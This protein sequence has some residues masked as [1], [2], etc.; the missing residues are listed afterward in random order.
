MIRNFAVF[1]GRLQGG[2]LSLGVASL[3][4]AILFGCGGGSGPGDPSPRDRDP[5]GRPLETYQQIGLIA[6][7]GHFPAVASLST[8][9]GPADSTYVLFG[10]SLPNNALRFQR[11][12]NGF[13]G[14]YTVTLAFARDSQV[15]Q[16]LERRE[17][18]RI[19]TFAET[20]RTDESIVF[21]QIVSL[22]P[23]TYVVN[24]QAADAHSSRGFRMTDTLDVPAYGALSHRLA[25]PILV[26]RGRG[27]SDRVAP[28]DIILN[29]RHTIPYGSDAPRVYIESYGADL[30]VPITL[31]V[32]D[33][34]GVTVWSAQAT[35]AEGDALV[36]H[37]TLDLPEGTLPLGKLWVEV[38]S[39]GQANSPRAPLVISIS[40]QWMVANFDEV[41]EFIRYI[42]SRAE[43]DSLQ[44]GTAAD[45]RERW[46]A[47][48]RR[49]DPLPAT[50]INEFR[51]EFF[52]RVRVATEQFAEP[53]GLPGWKTDRGEVY[54]VLGPPTYGEDRFI[55]RAEYSGRPNAVEWLYDNLPG[56]RMS[57]LFIDRTGFGRFELSPS[58]EA[59]FRAMAERLKPRTTEN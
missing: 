54:I 45:R 42:G 52:Q 4:L 20:G 34:A 36:R 13:M 19:G 17:A 8:M 11:D 18:V 31:S 26:Y 39:P 15:V 51:D 30:P 50:P 1:E 28:P 23:G 49:R 55:G 2:P 37:A 24:V 35:I 56:G 21:Q 16:R 38:S 25:Q 9:A 29:P 58:S 41:L 6:G 47:F 7:P 5:I 10:L 53:G 3:A 33:E 32:L 12:G 14:E 43:I 57:V 40:D 46:E 44:I 22:Q 48:W 59:S 27:R